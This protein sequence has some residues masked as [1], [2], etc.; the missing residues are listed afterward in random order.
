[1]PNQSVRAV[2]AVPHIWTPLGKYPSFGPTPTLLRP[3]RQTALHDH[4]LVR[5]HVPVLLRLR[6]TRETARHDDGTSGP[7]RA[8]DEERSA[9]EAG[10]ASA[11]AVRSRRCLP[12]CGAMLAEE[13]RLFASANE[14]GRRGSVP[15]RASRQPHPLLRL[16][17]TELTC[18]PSHWRRADVDERK[19][20]SMLARLSLAEIIFILPTTSKSEKARNKGQR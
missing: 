7:V 14:A 5:C 4:W 17:P 15:S 10:S 11:C 12:R 6:V 20:T 9:R 3:D 13:T 18:A 16:C 19:M 8:G 2:L 1:M